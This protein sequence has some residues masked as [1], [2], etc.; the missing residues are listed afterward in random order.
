MDARGEQ[1]QKK[2]RSTARGFGRNLGHSLFEPSTF[3]PQN[4]LSQGNCLV[5]KHKEEDPAVSLHP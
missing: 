2:L 3:L 1:N 5:L 4:G